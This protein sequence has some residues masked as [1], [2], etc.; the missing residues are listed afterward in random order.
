[1]RFAHRLGLAVV[2]VA[3]CL[4]LAATAAEAPPKLTLT[5]TLSPAAFAKMSGMKE[6]VTASVR[7]AGDPT[8]AAQ[9]KGV[10][11]EIGEIELGDEDLT[12]PVT[13]PSLSFAFVGKGFKAANMKWV[14]PG[15]Q[16]LSINVYSARKV[17]D[18]NLLDCGLF[19]GTFAEAAA[20]PVAMTCKLIDE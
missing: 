8:K 6:H 15:S 3:A 12:A 1:M 19:D 17:A 11:N 9:K 10:E 13:G 20:R 2:A 16:R 7:Y 18:D 5:V 14:A 4:P